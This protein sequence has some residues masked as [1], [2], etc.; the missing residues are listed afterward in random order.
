MS[1][2]SDTEIGRCVYKSAGIGCKDSGSFHQYY[3]SVDKKGSIHPR[4]LDKNAQMVARFSPYP[5]N[6]VMDY[7]IIHPLKDSKE[8]NRLNHQVRHKL[9]PSLSIPF[10]E[11]NM[12]KIVKD[13]T[14][15]Q[16]LKAFE[17]SCVNNP[18]IQLNLQGRY[19]PECPAINP[20]TEPHLDMPAFVLSMS[21][22]KNE[23]HFDALSKHMK[24][25]VGFKNVFRFLG[26][27]GNEKY[28][29][30]NKKFLKQDDRVHHLKNGELG[31]R[32]SMEEVLML[33]MK[34]KL[35]RIAV[36]DDDV[37]FHCNFKEKFYEAMKEQRCGGYSW[38][39]KSGGV[40]LLGSTHWVNGK[41]P[42]FNEQHYGGWYIADA[43][44]ANATKAGRKDGTLQ[45]GEKTHCFNANAKSF[46]SHAVIYHESVYSDILRWLR[47]EKIEPFDWV[48][49]W[50]GREGHI[51][52]TIYPFLAIQYLDHES[53]VD[54]QR[55]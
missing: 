30:E 45:K 34:L 38:S 49:R 22:E 13:V 37:Y 33:A 28:S 40:V 42:V 16:E 39:N 35:P 27:N 46:G 25:E 14:Y 7:A 52:R 2:H 20:D 32:D 43:D 51:T 8:I 47:E 24:E 26:V 23:K 11:K 29:P 54:N 3:S 21:G 15:K 53:S 55:T 12:L 18:S 1:V 44:M 48:F 17:N 5:N 50:L 41:Y 9:R 19:L 10:V 36:F 4:T 6:R 31:Y